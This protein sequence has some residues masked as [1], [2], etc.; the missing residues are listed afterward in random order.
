MRKNSILIKIWQMSLLAGAFATLPA[1]SGTSSSSSTPT[2]APT[3]A[4]T[5]QGSPQIVITAAGSYPAGYSSVAQFLVTNTSQTA[6]SGLTYQITDNTTGQNLSIN[7]NNCSS[8]SANGGTCLLSV[9]IP[10]NT[11]QGAFTVV[12]TPLLGNNNVS[13]S[14]ANIATSTIGIESTIQYSGYPFVILGTNQSIVATSNT[15]NQIL[16][17]VLVNN[18][19]NYNNLSFV[20]QNG[21]TL[22]AAPV[23][24]ISNSLGSVNTY[25]ISS[26]VLFGQSSQLIQVAPSVCN[27]SKCS[28]QSTTN[29]LQPDAGYLTISPGSL[30]L[31]GNSEETVVINNPSD[32]L[33]NIESFGVVSSIRDISYTLGTCGNFINST[34]GVITLSSKTSCTAKVSY[35]PSLGASSG[36]SQFFVKYA[37]GSGSITNTVNLTYSPTQIGP[38]TLLDVNPSTVNL[39]GSSGVNSQAV[40]LSNSS[41]N[42]SESN[43]SN[44]RITS[45]SSNITVSGNAACQSAVLAPNDSCTVNVGYS[46]AATTG[47]GLVQISYQVSGMPLATYFLTVNYTPYSTYSYV[48]SNSILDTNA[49]N[50]IYEYNQSASATTP[51]LAYTG[52][53]YDYTSTNGNYTVS[54]FHPVD[55]KYSNGYV[56]VANLESGI[57]GNADI[58]LYKVQTDGGLTYESSISLNKQISG[59]SALRIATVGYRVYAIVNDAIAIVNTNPNNNTLQF[60][61]IINSTELSSF[62][63]LSNL[64][65]IAI[66]QSGD[67]VLL[68]NY[69]TTATV[70][71]YLITDQGGSGTEWIGMSQFT[72]SPLGYINALAINQ[73][74]TDTYNYVGLFNLPE[75]ILYYGSDLVNSYPTGTYSLANS[76]TQAALQSLPKSTAINETGVVNV[77]ISD[78]Y[79]YYVFAGLEPGVAYYGINPVS[80]S[81]TDAGSSYSQVMITPPSGISWAPNGIT[82]NQ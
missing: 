37:N 27:S 1:C 8:V 28:N 63:I 32:T 41:F 19:N 3:P 59:K 38:L 73:T 33:L 22:T 31:V 36:V 72:Y 26:P 21:D 35:S 6:A 46:G 34:T 64:R 71:T 66:S 11:P 4:P 18:S 76:L 62:G 24:T 81:I 52:N 43:I 57:N 15:E 56:Y 45:L 14:G 30:S 42:G 9:N 12:E 80:G 55:V 69:G 7:S 53:S 20:D 47:S 23:G 13:A 74:S 51:S 17:S 54:N 70:A 78:G 40:T 48:V 10:A 58:L 44:I 77:G 50:A 68:G 25:Q 82:F 49:P 79:L 67:E 5:P 2:P 75:N 60:G 29:I 61:G 65:S 16:V 39:D